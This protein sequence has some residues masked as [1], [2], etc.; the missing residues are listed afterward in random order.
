MSDGGIIKQLWEEESESGKSQTPRDEKVET[1]IS[2]RKAVMSPDPVLCRRRWGRSR[3]RGL[4]PRQRSPLSHR[5]SASRPRRCAFW[6]FFPWCIPYLRWSTSSCCMTDSGINLCCKYHLPDHLGG[7]SVQHWSKSERHMKSGL[8]AS[9]SC[10]RVP[11]QPVV[12]FRRY[13][14]ETGSQPLWRSVLWNDL[15]PLDLMRLHHKC[16]S[17]ASAWT[18]VQETTGDQ[19]FHQNKTAYSNNS[20]QKKKD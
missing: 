7:K 19:A 11:R 13:R 5:C 6:P 9:L 15:H 1:L 10:E 16:C 3:K 2:L 14:R 4:W 18:G 12:S 20:R 8:C 17:E